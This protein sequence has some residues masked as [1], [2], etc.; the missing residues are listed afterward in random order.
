MVLLECFLDLY[1][2]IILQDYVTSG[3]AP[4]AGRRRSIAQ[5]HCWESSKTFGIKVADDYTSPWYNS[6]RIILLGLASSFI[7][8][9]ISS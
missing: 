4:R 3:R 8:P 2:V 1:V 9:N 7:A 5:Q 6:G